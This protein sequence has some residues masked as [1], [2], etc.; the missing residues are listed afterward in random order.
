MRRLTADYLAP[1]KN[2]WLVPNTSCNQQEVEEGEPRRW[3]FNS[4]RAHFII[5]MK[6]K[7][8]YC[9]IFALFLIILFTILFIFFMIF[10]KV[11]FAERF[12]E[13]ETIYFNDGEGNICKGTYDYRGFICEEKIGK[14]KNQ[15][16]CSSYNYDECPE[17]C[18]IC[19]PCEVCSSI[20]CQTEEFCNNLGFNKSWYESVKPK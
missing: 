11:I 18:A 2:H 10:G 17:K 8:K 16:D 14:T 13:N 5:K 3:G 20:S 6:N 19:P 12:P 4:L 15:K 9:I 7:K 1:D